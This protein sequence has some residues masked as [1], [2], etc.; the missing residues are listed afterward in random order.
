MLNLLFSSTV[1]EVGCRGVLHANRGEFRFQ[2]TKAPFV[3]SDCFPRG[4]SGLA[5]SVLRIVKHTSILTQHFR[6]ATRAV[7]VIC[8]R[9]ARSYLSNYAFCRTQVREDGRGGRANSRMVQA[10][11]RAPIQTRRP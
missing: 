1:G 6:A 2:F 10:A 11:Q 3:D 7:P 8:I 9:S 5:F 4:R